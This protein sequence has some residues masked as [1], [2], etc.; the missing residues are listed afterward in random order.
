MPDL[1]DEYHQGAALD[2]VDNPVVPDTQ[3]K[4]S[5]SSAQGRR[6][7]RARV[8]GQ[9]VNPR[10]EAALNIRGESAEVPFRSRG[11]DDAVDAGRQLQPQ[12]CLDLLPGNRALLPGLCQC[13]TGVVQIQALL[14]RLQE[15]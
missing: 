5:F 10:L 13:G 15:R 4:K 11:E 12:F 8:M 9:S 3:P 1:Q 7:P 2:L 6:S 14:Q